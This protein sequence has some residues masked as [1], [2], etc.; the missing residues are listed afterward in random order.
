VNTHPVVPITGALLGR[1][2]ALA[3]AQDGSRTVASLASDRV[4]YITGQGTGVN[5]G[6]TAS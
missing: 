3:F 1:A 6:G 2:I 5:G 4:D